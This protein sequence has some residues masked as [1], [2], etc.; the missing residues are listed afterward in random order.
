[1]VHRRRST[2]VVSVDADDNT[3]EPSEI[4]EF[5]EAGFHVQSFGFDGETVA[6]AVTPSSDGLAHLVWSTSIV[7]SYQMALWNGIE[8]PSSDRVKAMEHYDS[9]GR[10]LLSAIRSWSGL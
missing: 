9:D 2:K 10:L 6:L 7:K 4:I 8:K 1:M 5:D 3:A